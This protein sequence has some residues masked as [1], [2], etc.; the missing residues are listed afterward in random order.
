MKALVDSSLAP[1]RERMAR[2]F[3]RSET[4]LMRYDLLETTADDFIADA[5]RETAKTDIG[6]TNGFR[7]GSPVPPGQ[8]TDADLWN[9]LPMDLRM[10]SGWVTGKEL[11]AY[12]ENELETVYSK[13]PWKL[14]GGWGARA[15]GLTL[16]F[17]ARADYGRRVVS[18]KVNGKEIEPDGRY[19]DRRVRTARRAHRHD[20]PPPWHPRSKNARTV[21]ARGA[22][23]LSE[24]PPSHCAAPRRS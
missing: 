21:G 23:A 10:K 22:R 16:T 13:D 9:L 4:V 7:F 6:L 20:L 11:R 1:H 18:I 17:K 15:S 12:F 24:K 8:L 5:V 14:N 2:Q 3:G 19:T